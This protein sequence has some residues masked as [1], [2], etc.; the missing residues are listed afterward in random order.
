MKFRPL[1]LLRAWRTSR[2]LDDR[3][4][5]GPSCPREQAVIHALLSDTASL[6]MESAD[7][8]IARRAAQRIEHHRLEALTG[9]H[10]HT[11]RRNAWWERPAVAAILLVAFASVW[12][13]R[14][15]MTRP[16]GTGLSPTAIVADVKESHRSQAE[17]DLSDTLPS[18]P[19][20]A[21]YSP[22]RTTSAQREFEDDAR[23]LARA[24]LEALPLRTH[25][26]E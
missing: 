6:P 16:A 24:M 5:P 7:Q 8:P 23:A 19:E 26:P 4:A 14:V 18:Q 1:E 10:A 9:L 15:L 25:E 22:L 21:L 17:K 2:V 3:R 20:V 13:A 11:P 12:G